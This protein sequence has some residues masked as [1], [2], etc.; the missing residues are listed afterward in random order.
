MPSNS[1]NKP[2]RITLQTV[3]RAEGQVERQSHT[4]EGKYYQKDQS[5]HLIYQ[6]AEGRRAHLRISAGEV[7][8]HR[9]GDLSG[10]LWFIE[11]DERDA[12][13]ETP[14]GRMILTVD[15]KKLRW[16]EN[17]RRLEVAYRL[18]AGEQLLSENEMIITMEDI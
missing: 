16:E 8:V 17:T 12:R 15:T 11:G 10:D 13:Y 3:Q 4:Y 2:V 7:H 18:L 9:L 14:Y 5:H 6:E 1:E